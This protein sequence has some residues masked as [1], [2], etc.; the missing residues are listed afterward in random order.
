[1]LTPTYPLLQDMLGGMHGALGSE[2][3]DLGSC[4]LGLVAA[5]FTPGPNLLIS[6]LTEASFVGYARKSIGALTPAF[7]GPQQLL[8][9]QGAELSWA[10]S[11]TTT[12]NVIYGAFLTGSADT[13]TVKASELFNAPIPITGPLSRLT[14]VPRIGYDPFG[15]YGLGIAS[16]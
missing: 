2:T 3:F 14:Y 8:L 10:A 9:T 12:T 15:N 13:T 5:P 16:N 6:A 11:D 4:S 7:I 1:M